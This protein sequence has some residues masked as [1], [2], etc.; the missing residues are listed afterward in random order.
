MFRPML[1]IGV[2]GSGGKTLR[3]MKQA[4]E[5]RLETARYAGGIPGCWQFLQIDTTYDG[6]D[7]PAPMLD[8]FAEF[9]SVIAPGD[10]FAGIL[11]N[12]TSN[13]TRPEQ[14]RMMAG[15]GIPRCQVE[16]RNGAGQMRGIGRLVGIADSPI[17]I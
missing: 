12:M 13:A 17:H 9:K 6:Q 14:Q 5:R 8:P 16:V 15:W 11:H 3:S 4:I 2:G 7:F 1:I 10:D